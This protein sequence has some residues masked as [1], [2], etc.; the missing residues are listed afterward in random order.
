MSGDYELAATYCEPK[1]GPG[2][3]IQILTHG[4]GV[5]RSYWDVPYHNWNYS[6]VEAALDKG[7]STLTW[8]RPGIGGSSK[9]DPVDDI[10][11]FLEIAALE[12]LTSKLRNGTLWGVNTHYSKMVHVGHSF[13]SAIT[14]GFANAHP[15]LS[16]GIVLTGFTQVPNYIGLFAVAGNFIPVSK[17]PAAADAYPTGYVGVS[18]SAGVQTNFF[19]SGDFDPELL[20]FAFE[21]GQPAA[22]GEFL[23]VASG[24]GEPSSFKGPVLII[25]G[26]KSDASLG[27]NRRLTGSR[28]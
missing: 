1:S 5:D 11:I 21:N 28:T 24:A 7:Y 15:M 9:G 26:G 22:Y 23:T 16:D 27:S 18:S 8:D 10:Q 3:T 25:T 4:V 12:R 14:Y 20:Q 17:I 2:S 6:Y 13:G 19:G